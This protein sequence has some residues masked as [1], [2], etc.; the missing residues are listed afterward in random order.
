L[1]RVVMMMSGP[2]LMET[3]LGDVASSQS[4]VDFQQRI[5]K[6]ELVSL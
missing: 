5:S 4:L 1:T 3:V 6:N 2:G